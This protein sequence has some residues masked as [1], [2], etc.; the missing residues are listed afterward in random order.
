MPT[1]LLAILTSLLAMSAAATTTARATANKSCG[2]A[3]FGCSSL[4]QRQKVSTARVITAL[5]N[6]METEGMRAYSNMC[7]RHIATATATATAAATH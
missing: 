4:F 2:P 6:Y 7:S 5:R 1:T 3:S